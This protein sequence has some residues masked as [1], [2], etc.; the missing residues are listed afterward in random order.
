[1]SILQFAF[2]GDAGSSIFL[3]HNYSRATVVYTGTHDNDTTLGWWSSTGEGD[4]TRA[5]EDVAREKAFALRYLDAD[6]REMNW[7]FIRATI[8]SVADTVIIPLQ[9]V[10]GLGSEARMN[11]PGRA[12][13]NWRFRFS[14]DQLSPDIVRRLRDLVEIYDR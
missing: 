14:W 3:P 12:S 2:G 1:M 9:D 10:L 8:A 6:G 4:S 11:L 5:P 7:T 13:G